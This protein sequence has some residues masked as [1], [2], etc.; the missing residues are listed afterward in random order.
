MNLMYYA[1][2]KCLPV[3]FVWQVAGMRGDVGKCVGVWG[4]QGEM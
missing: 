3:L 4:K 1:S 2:D